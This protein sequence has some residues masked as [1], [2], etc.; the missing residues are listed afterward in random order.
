MAEPEPQP[1]PSL[2]GLMA[3]L[4]ALSRSA[5]LGD[6]ELYHRALEAAHRQQATK[7]QILDAY[8]WGRRDLG[9]ADFDHHGQPR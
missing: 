8:R 7:E 4:D 5:R 3:A 6:L 9:A 2:A 1:R